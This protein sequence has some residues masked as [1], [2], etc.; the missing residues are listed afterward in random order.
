[1]ARSAAPSRIATAFVAD[2]VAAAAMAQ[3]GR[4]VAATC[5]LVGLL[6]LGFIYLW[7]DLVSVAPAAW[8]LAARRIVRIS[9]APRS[10]PRDVKLW[11]VALMIFW[12]CCSGR[13][14]GGARLPLA[15]GACGTSPVA[16]KAVQVLSRGTEGGMSRASSDRSCGS[17]AAAT[18]T[19]K[20]TP[21]GSAT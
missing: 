8:S 14:P 5:L 18:P 4:Q 7:F 2:L 11:P 9:A 21:C 10:G 20:Q 3:W 17:C 1:V 16:S 6:L 12:F 15:P 19:G 13:G